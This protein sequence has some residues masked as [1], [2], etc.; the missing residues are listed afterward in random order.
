MR[1]P[2]LW[3][4]N[5]KWVGKGIPHFFESCSI[6][7]S[8]DESI[9]CTHSKANEIRYLTRITYIFLKNSSNFWR[10]RTWISARTC[11][12]F[13]HDTTWK[14]LDRNSRLIHAENGES[15]LP[16]KLSQFCYGFKDIRTY[17]KSSK[18]VKVNVKSSTAIY[19]GF[20]CTHNIHKQRQIEP[21]SFTV[22]VQEQ[23]N[24]CS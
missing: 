11:S 8:M 1:V 9:N 18:G 7:Y 17:R 23:P 10:R 4:H 16:V 14:N 6:R 19:S 24:V 3:A 13:P 20:M 5:I 21:E 2:I 12:D 15:K 22:Y